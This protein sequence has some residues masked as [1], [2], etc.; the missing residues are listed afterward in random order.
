MSTSFCE[1]LRNPE[2]YN[3]QEVTARATWR[4]GFEWSQFYGLAC[5]E[6]GRACLEVPTNLDDASTKALGL[7]PKGRKEI[8][9]AHT[10]RSGYLISRRK[11]RRRGSPCDGRGLESWPSSAQHRAQGQSLER[12]SMR[13]A[14]DTHSPT[15]RAYSQAYPRPRRVGR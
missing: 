2:K 14:L 6:K 15:I 11:F 7:I 1:L 10:S 9:L 8:L 5:L 13:H 3:G 12:P 4:Y